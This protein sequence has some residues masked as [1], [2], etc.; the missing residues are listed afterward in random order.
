MKDPKNIH[1]IQIFT[2]SETTGDN[3]WVVVSKITF[4]IVYKAPQDPAAV[5]PLL[6]WTPSRILATVDFNSLYWAWQPDL[7]RSYGLDEEIETW[8][9]V[10]NLSS[11]IIGESNHHA[12]NTLDLVF[13]NFMEACARVDRDEC[14]TNDYYSF[15]GI[16]PCQRQREANKNGPFN[17]SEDQLPLFAEIVSKWLLQKSFTSIAK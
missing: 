9:E 1:A 6:S 16:A 14:V 11:L 5:Q 13:K 17:V 15:P 10:H 12:V 3:C 7:T 4:L 8:A 2:Y